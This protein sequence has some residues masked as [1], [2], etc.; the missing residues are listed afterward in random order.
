MFILEPIHFAAKFLHSR[1]R[2]LR[3][4][5]NAEIKSCKIDVRRQ[6][7]EIEER[8]KLKRSFKNQQSKVVSAQDNVAEPPLKRKKNRF[9]QEYKSGELCDEYGE[10]EV[11]VDKYL[12]MRVDPEFMADNTLIFWTKANQTNLLLLSKLARMIHYIPASTASMER[13]FSGGELIVSE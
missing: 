1:Y 5:S 8:K 6:M 2:H 12:S 9:G 11:E 13:E 4:Y 3:N 10:A 7:Q